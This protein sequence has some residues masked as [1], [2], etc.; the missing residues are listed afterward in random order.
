MRKFVPG[1]LS[2]QIALVMAGALLIASIVNFAMLVGERQR[3]GV[4]E[5]SGP[6]IARFVDVAAE[7]FAAPPADF[8]R[9]TMQGRP[10]GPRFTLLPN[11][12]VDALGLPRDARLEQRL[13]R[14]LDEAGVA[15]TEVRVSSRVVS[16][17]QRGRQDNPFNPEGR[18]FR[19][20][21]FG[22][23]GPPNPGAPRDIQPGGPPPDLLPGFGVG[24]RERSDLRVREIIIAA[25]LPDQRWLNVIAVSPLQPNDELWR[26]GAT[27]FVFD[28]GNQQCYAS[29]DRVLERFSPWK[30][31]KNTAIV[32]L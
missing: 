25:Q 8:Q 7:V 23:D 5:Q 9:Y 6:T 14:G 19:L 24:G 29:F 11:N 3:A 17:Q 10:R 4:N 20:R 30:L 16:R 28:R 22:P 18:Q 2:G 32:R 31:E 21:Q 12:P 15:A 13:R 27:T 1:N 26:L